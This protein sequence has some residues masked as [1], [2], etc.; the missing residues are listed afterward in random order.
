[1]KQRR[2]PGA[3]YRCRRCGEPKRGHICAARTLTDEVLEGQALTEKAAALTE[4]SAL[5]LQTS[6]SIPPTLVPAPP[7]FVAAL[8]PQAAPP[9][10]PHAA[11]AP[12]LASAPAILSAAAPLP[13]ANAMPMA[14]PLAAPGAM[15]YAPPPAGPPLAAPPAPIDASGAAVGVDVDDFL[16]ELCAALESP[17]PQRAP[18]AASLAAA[19]PAPPA[20]GPAGELPP[21]LFSQQSLQDALAAAMAEPGLLS[22]F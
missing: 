10:P 20:A 9:M 19:P 7:P 18:A 5:K 22:A 6:P 2:A 11:A 8:P 16:F 14:A 12:P 17:S 1:M 15:A 21:P 3:G 4:L 13:T